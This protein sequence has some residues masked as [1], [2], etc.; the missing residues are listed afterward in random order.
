MRI[1]R[2]H[3]LLMQQVALASRAMKCAQEDAVVWVKKEGKFVPM[4]KYLSSKQ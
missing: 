1:A 2:A 4:L 3:E